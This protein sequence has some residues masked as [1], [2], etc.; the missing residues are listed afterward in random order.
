MRSNDLPASVSQ[1]EFAEM[2]GPERLMSQY[3]QLTQLH[4]DLDYMI[5]A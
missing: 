4:H 1:I 5:S 2:S 3:V